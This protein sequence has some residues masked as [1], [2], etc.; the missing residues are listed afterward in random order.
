MINDIISK[1]LT[2]IRLYLFSE[3][4]WIRPSSALIFLCGGDIKKRVTGR[5][6]LLEYAK[7]HISN[8]HFFL[9]EDVFKLLE[10]KN[11]NLLDTENTLAEYADCILI[12]LESDGAKVE[13]GSFAGNTKLSSKIIVI[14]D[15]EF[16]EEKSFI[17]LGPLD[18]INKESKF[19]ITEKN[20]FPVI[21]APLGEKIF[22]AYSKIEILLEEFVKSKKKR[23]LGIKNT[24]DFQKASQD[25]MLFLADL[26]WIFSPITH[27]TLVKYILFI[28]EEDFDL[29]FNKELSFLISLN[30]IT[31]FEYRDNTYYYRSIKNE[32][33]LF[34]EFS[35]LEKSFNLKK[36][37]LLH[38]RRT[39][40]SIAE[41]T[42]AIY[43]NEINR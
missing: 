3:T 35:T 16:K 11:H 24:D 39:N 33:D 8:C 41:I 28:F 25:R 26:I 38:F 13:L 20:V 22:E 34:C 40:K 23:K 19:K 6:S 18:K 1:L 17:S 27:K 5:K 37:F 7:K 4:I 30:M 36:M 14:N 29:K 15:T 32:G 43:E 31:R 9:A 12:I 21:Y 2:T 42:Q 10:D